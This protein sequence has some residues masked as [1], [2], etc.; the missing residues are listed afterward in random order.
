[1]VSRQTWRLLPDKK[2]RYQFICQNNG[3]LICLSGSHRVLKDL[4]KSRRLPSVPTWQFVA[5]IPGNEEDDAN[6]GQPTADD[7][8]LAKPW[9]SWASALYSITYPRRSFDF[10]ENAQ[11][12]TASLNGR[13]RQVIAIWWFD[14]YFSGNLGQDF[15]NGSLGVFLTLMISLLPPTFLD[16]FYFPAERWGRCVQKLSRIKWFTKVQKWAWHPHFPTTEDFPD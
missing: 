14:E 7:P 2:P 5:V 9:E 13:W 6:A 8:L 3:N 1:M 10:Q 4:P 16:P 12:W 15:W 11:R